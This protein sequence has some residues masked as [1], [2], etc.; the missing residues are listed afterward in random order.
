MVLKRSIFEVRQNYVDMTD[1]VHHNIRTARHR[2]IVHLHDVR[3]FEQPMDLHFA[4]GIPLVLDAV[5]GDPLHGV[6][7]LVGRIL[8]QIDEAEATVEP[9][10]AIFRFSKE[11]KTYRDTGWNTRSPLGYVIF[12]HVFGSVHHKRLLRAKA[13]HFEEDRPTYAVHRVRSF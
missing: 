10:N 12:D 8:D 3:V 11:L 9:Q 5:A 4:Q 7:L 2:R 1:L 6:S 13:A